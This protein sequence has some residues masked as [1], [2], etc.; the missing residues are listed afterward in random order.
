MLTFDKICKAIETQDLMEELQ[1]F[2]KERDMKGEYNAI[3]RLAMQMSNKDFLKWLEQYG[4]V[5]EHLKQ[6]ILNRKEL[7]QD[8][9]FEA[10]CK[11]GVK[12]D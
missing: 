3:M 10:Y 6:K 4:E 8:E 12:N 7:T 5:P 2:E 11:T 1:P 9:M